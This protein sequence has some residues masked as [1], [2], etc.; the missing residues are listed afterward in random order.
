[1]GRYIKRELHH[2]EA[3]EEH[4]EQ[5]SGQLVPDAEDEDD[6][7][8][9]LPNYYRVMDGVPDLPWNTLWHDNIE[10]ADLQNENM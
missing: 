2:N 5:P 9:Q 3:D 1:M 7:D 8:D 4:T 10:E 6:S